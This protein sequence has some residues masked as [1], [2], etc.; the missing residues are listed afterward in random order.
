MESDTDREEDIRSSS[1]INLLVEDGWAGMRLDQF[2]SVKLPFYSRSLINSAIRKGTVFV[3]GVHKKSSNRLKGGSTITGHVEEQQQISVSPEK[4]D[5]EILHED[6]S[7]LLLSKP[8]GLVV[9]PGSG[10]HKGTLVN[11]LVQ[12]CM[13]IAAVGDAV[14]PGIVHRLDKDTSGIMVVAKTEK[15]H[16]DLIECFKRHDLTKEYIALVHGVVSKGVGRIAAP[17]G[18]HPV[19]RQKM[20]VRENGGKHAATSWECL[21]IINNKF[22]LLKIQI[23]TGRTHQIRVHMAHLGYPVAGDTVYGRGRDNSLF[24][25]HM[26]HAFRLAFHHPE[27]GLFIDQKAPLYAD[28]STVL[29]NLGTEKEMSQL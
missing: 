22:S 18:R 5:F 24:P 8:P 1:Q 3:D 12:H 17:I 15:C 14:R 19:Q 25:R 20:A 21:E 13:E 26:L 11:G 6:R 9:H 16:R 4:I 23:E 27:T 7:L 29:K 28:F 10:N 2:L